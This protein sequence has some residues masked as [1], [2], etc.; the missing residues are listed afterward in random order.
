MSGQSLAWTQLLHQLASLDMASL[1]LSDAC[2][3]ALLQLPCITSLNLGAPSLSS[4]HAL[5]MYCTAPEVQAADILSAPV[6]LALSACWCSADTDS[7][8]QPAAS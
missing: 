5:H 6:L 2:V 4:V 7:D 1:R 8:L 3:E